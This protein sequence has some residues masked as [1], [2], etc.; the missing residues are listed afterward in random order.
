M[1]LGGNISP[2]AWYILRTVFLPDMSWL[3]KANFNPHLCFIHSDC[4]CK[5]EPAPNGEHCMW[6]HRDPGDKEL[7]TSSKEYM[8]KTPL[9]SFINYKFHKAYYP[10]F[11]NGETQRWSVVTQQGKHLPPIRFSKPDLNYPSGTYYQEILWHRAA[12]I[13]LIIYQ[14]KPK[15]SSGDRAMLSLFYNLWQHYF[16][17]SK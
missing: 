3:G 7:Y 12:E 9:S 11:A 15:Q 6:R 17:T 13:S 5:R 16:C 10:Q 1:I 4:F 8:L 14:L 2:T